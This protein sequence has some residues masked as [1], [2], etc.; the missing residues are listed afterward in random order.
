MFPGGIVLKAGATLD[1]AGVI[2][3][4]G[5]TG[6]GVTLQGVFFEAPNIVSTGG[7]I[8]VFTNDLNWVNFSTYPHAPFSTWQLS[9]VPGGQYAYV[10]ADCV[11]PH[12]NTYS[13]ITE[14]AASGQCWTC[15]VNNTPM[16]SAPPAPPPV[17]GAPG[18]WTKYA[19]SYAAGNE[20]EYQS[21][22][23]LAYDP[24]RDVFYGVSWMGVIASFSPS[25]GGWTKLSPDIGGGVHNRTTAYDPLNDRVWLG[26]GT[27][28]TLTGVNYFDP[29][30]KKWI[31]HPMTGPV[32]GTQSAMIYDAASKRFIVFGGWNL[33][34][35]RRGR[36]IRRRAS[37][38]DA[39]VSGGPVYN[40][41][42]RR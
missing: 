24:K 28:S 7:D 27:G 5:W 42:A 8:K 31:S 6:A 33:L 23:N 25:A 16:N 41:D 18:A 17:I 32:F 22:Y 15:L 2:V 20:A 13:A 9:G 1:L 29:N 30:T 10:S 12:L 35:S 39:G 11:A 19:I 37:M 36:S 21:W 34:A 14:A 26:A 40:S 3:D 38:V 4:N